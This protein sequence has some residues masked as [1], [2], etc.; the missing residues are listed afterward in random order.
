MEHKCGAQDSLV[1]IKQDI[2]E[3]KENLSEHMARTAANE[4]Q[5]EI[6]RNFI[7]EQPNMFDR[8]ERMDKTNKV[9]VYKILIGGVVT[10]LLPL[11]TILIKAWAGL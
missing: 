10:G 8:F 7:R 1:E 2:R 11:I 3:I 6:L 5:L 9:F 4:A